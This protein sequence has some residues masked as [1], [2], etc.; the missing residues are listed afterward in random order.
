MRYTLTNARPAAGHGR[1]DPGGPRRLVATPAGQREPC[2]GPSGR[3]TSGSGMCRSRP[4]ARRSSP[5]PSTRA[6]ERSMRGIASPARGA[7]AA[8]A[9]RRRSSASPRRRPTRSRSPS[10]ASPARGLTR[11]MNLDWL[12]GYALISETRHGRPPGRASRH[13]LRG[14]RRRHRPGRARSSPGLP[15]R[16]AE[17]NRDARLL[18]PGG[19][20]DALARPARPSP[21]HLARDRRGAPSRTRSSAPAPT[22]RSCSQTA[23]G[24][25]ALRCT[26]L[27]ETLVYRR[28]AAR[29]SPPSRRCRSGRAA[30]RRSTATVTLSYL[31]SEF[32]LA[33]QLCRALSPDGRP[34]DL[35]AWLTLA[36]GDETS[37][38]DAAHPGRRRPLNR[39]DRCGRRGRST[40]AGRSSLRCWP[41]RHGRHR[42]ATP[43]RRQ[44]RR[45]RRRCRSAAAKTS[46]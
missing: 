16:P 34:V 28:R 30:P 5:R 31:A 6:T 27:P 36:N 21:P 24:F 38:A 33:G 41:R 39:E 8:D 3:S 12:D 35:F 46:S 23:E 18:S 2:R 9:R 26:G 37:F 4:M 10:I 22:A 17:K 40:G 19:L 20:L 13:P 11:T 7:G 44:H 25:E 45:R 15:D 42:D 14:R 32:R 29:A 1:P 43:F